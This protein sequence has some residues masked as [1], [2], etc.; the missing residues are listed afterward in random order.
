MAYQ[1]VSVI[2]SKE[3]CPLFANKVG[4]G[5]KRLPFQVDLE[6]CTNCRACI[7]E[8]ACPAFHL[9][10]DRPAIRED[11]CIGCSVCSQ[12]CSEKAIRP[13]KGNLTKKTPSVRPC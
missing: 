1:G 9:D 12:I 6:K 2:I 4:I 3:P 7:N 8:I 10:N 5:K 11:V 13:S